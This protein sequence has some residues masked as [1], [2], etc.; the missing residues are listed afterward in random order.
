MSLCQNLSDIV[1][2]EGQWMWFSPGNETICHLCQSSTEKN[3][4]LVN[5]QNI[6]VKVSGK[7]EL[8]GKH[9]DQG[10]PEV[11]LTFGDTCPKERVLI[12]I[13]VRRV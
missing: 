1:P 4:K 13:E 7:G 10:N 8:W 12:A 3:T 5:Y 9:R 6:Y 11:N 2:E